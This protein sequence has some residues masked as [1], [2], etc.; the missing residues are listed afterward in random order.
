MNILKKTVLSIILAVGLFAP[1]I[2]KNEPT[3]D[4]KLAPYQVVID[5]VNAEYNTSIYI[6]DEN[7]DK[8]YDKIKDMT[9]DEVKE[10]LIQSLESTNHTTTDNKTDTDYTKDSCVL[11]ENNSVKTK[12]TYQGDYNKES[13]VGK[14]SKPDYIPNS[15]GPVKVVPLE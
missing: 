6:P 2:V 9:G 15:T 7:K 12:N 1:V 3:I 13:A 11:Q 4:E 8:V 14:T 5:K 10:M